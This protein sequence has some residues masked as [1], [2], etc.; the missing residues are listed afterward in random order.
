MATNYNLDSYGFSQALILTPPYPIALEIDPTTS[1]KL[2]PGTIW[3]NTSTNAVF[4][5]ASVKNNSAN[6]VNISNGAGTFTSLTVNPGDV[7][8][9]AGNLNVIA[10]SG[11]FGS[12]LS[13]GTNISTTNGSLSIGSTSTTAIDGALLRFNRSRSGGAINASDE[14]GEISFLGRRSAGFAQ[15]AKITSTATAVALTT[16]SGNLQFYTTDN[17]ISSTLR[18][19]IAETGNVSIATASIGFSL[20]VDGGI[21]VASSDILVS[22]GDIEI[23]STATVTPDAPA[24]LDMTRSRAGGVIVSGDQLGSIDFSGNDGTSTSI[25]ATILAT[26]TGTIATGQ[27]PTN[28][29]IQTQPDSANPLATRVLISS[30]GVI[31]VN[32]AES[33][34]GTTMIVSGG[35]QILTGGFDVQGSVGGTITAGSTITGASVGASDDRT[36]TPGVISLSN[37]ANTAANSTGTF[38][39]KSKSA[40]NLDSTGFIKIWVG[41]TE[42]Y[43]PIFT[44]P[45]P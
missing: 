5:L 34:A 4:I 36:G 45:S 29:E 23:N 21:N 27:I 42:Y 31:T 40:N 35:A 24:V 13:V 25:G 26:S 10:G 9:V 17:S 15:A 22:N 37:V 33:G 41:A 39:I 30:E 32:A 43:I 6:W 20:I 8:I 1:N 12:S 28:L 2:I 7:T 18:M 16:L 19:T 44:T 38:T 14:I 3:C 11:T